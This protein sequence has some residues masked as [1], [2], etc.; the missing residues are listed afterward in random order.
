M[1]IPI[2]SKAPVIERQQ[3]LIPA[4]PA[5]V[6]QVL[7]D[8]NA[9]PEW[10][11]SVS[12]AK[13]RGAPVEGTPFTWKAGGIRLKSSIHTAQPS[14]AF[15]WTGKT[16]GASAVHNWMLEPQPEGTLVKVEE[17]LK[18]FLPL[19]FRAKFQKDLG[20]GMEL[21]LRELKVRAEMM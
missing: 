1:N 10:Q 8:I 17:S 9:W 21:N 2:N 14:F 18:G 20:R 19:L 11:S 4:D 6:W 5:V 12:Q 13:L 16:W 15:G 7:T 3:I